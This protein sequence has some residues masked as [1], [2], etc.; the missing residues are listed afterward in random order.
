MRS[1]LILGMCA[2][3]LY[4]YFLAISWLQL[5]VV[6]ISLQAFMGSAL[7]AARFPRWLGIFMMTACIVIEWRKGTGVEGLVTEI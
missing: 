1:Y 3:Y 2:I 4:Q 6:A 7:N 5:V